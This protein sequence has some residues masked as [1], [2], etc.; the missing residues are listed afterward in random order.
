VVPNTSGTLIM[1][2]NMVLLP[3]STHQGMCLR[4]NSSSVSDLEKEYVTTE[5]V[6]NI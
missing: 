2:N 4:E 5:K 3:I 6:R 1:V